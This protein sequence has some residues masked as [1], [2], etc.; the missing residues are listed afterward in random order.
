MSQQAT[1]ETP[2]IAIIGGGPGG[3][4][5]ARILHLH[6]IASTVFERD[7]HALARPQGGSLDMHADTGLRALRLA[8]LEDAFRAVARYED[9]DGKVYSPDGKLLFADYDPEGER[10]EID[11]T[12]LRQLFLDALPQGTV[13][14]G[15][16][17]E[18]VK[19]LEDGRYAVFA[20][21]GAGEPFDLVVGADGAWSRV[22]PLVSD[23]VPYYEGVIFCELGIDDAD[24]RHPALAALVGHGK[25]FAKGRSRTLVGQRSSNAHIRVYAALRA[26][27]TAVVLDAADPDRTRQEIAGHFADFAP[28]LRALITEARLLAIRPM[29]ALAVGHRWANRPGVTLI[30]DAAHLMSPFGGE[31][32]NTA[33]ADGADLAMA[34]AEGGD[35]RQAV[36]AYEAIM[37]PRAEEAAGGAAE[38][39][40]GGVSEDA[41]D[42]ILEHVAAARE[43]A[44]PGNRADEGASASG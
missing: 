1:T 27:V 8:G 7:E 35:W 15:Q 24:A 13:R 14:W 4:T 31:G 23:A 41:P 12:Q 37:F 5:L 6:G 17:I 21:G 44:H 33:M 19:P 29:Y 34:L 43:R 20:N 25:M 40:R 18:A 11:R 39:L 10:P 16:K 38:G 32:A 28:G 9:Q 36:A 2:T 22:R 30:G 3:L 42:H 26:P